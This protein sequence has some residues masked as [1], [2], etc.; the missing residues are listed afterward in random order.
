[1]LAPHDVPAYKKMRSSADPRRRFL[2]HVYSLYHKTGFIHPDPLEFLHRYPHVQDREVVGLVASSLAYGRVGQILRSVT[3][4]L[5][6]MGD[7][8]G[9]FIERT[10]RE[11]LRERFRGFKHR[12]TTADELVDLL[13]ATGKVISA[14]GSLHACFLEG[15]DHRHPDVTEALA[16]FVQRIR[17]HMEP[18]ENS[19]LPCPER[20]SACKRLYLF[21]RWMVRE[22]DVDPGGWKGISPS[23]LI[24]PVDVHMHR[25]GI[26]LGMTDRRQADLRTA[27]EITEGFRKIVPDDPVRYDFSLTRIGIRNDVDIRAG[28]HYYRELLLNPK[29]SMRG[30]C[31]G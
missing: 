2:E 25:I 7:S 1:M 9:L 20:K 26:V 6:G 14:Y 18:V 5:E 10:S 27:M 24:V 22:D 21:L 19:L 15:F 8:P 23:K 13:S 3:S 28:M 11:D 31:Y 30:V 29:N 4:V 16:A 17:D 12:F